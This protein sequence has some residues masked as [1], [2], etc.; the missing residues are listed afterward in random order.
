MRLADPETVEEAGNIE[1]MGKRCRDMSREEL[2]AFIWQL[3]HRIASLARL[4]G[5]DYGAQGRA[6]H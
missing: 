6:V 4:Q 3:D 1:W 5:D 2:L